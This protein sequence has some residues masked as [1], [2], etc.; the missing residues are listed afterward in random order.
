M[1]IADWSSMAFRTINKKVMFYTINVFWAPLCIFMYLLLEQLCR[2]GLVVSVST[3]HAVGR[4]FAP[5]YVIS[6][7]IIKMVQT[8]SL[9]GTHMLW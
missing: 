7:I 1:I 8:A 5:G 6:K 3:S 9:L 4:D 2:V